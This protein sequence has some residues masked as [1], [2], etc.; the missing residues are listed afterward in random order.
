MRGEDIAGFDISGHTGAGVSGSDIFCAA[1]S[2]A[3][4]LTVNTITDVMGVEAKVSVSEGRLR[5]VLENGA[6]KQCKPLLIGFMLHMKQLK[7][8]RPKS[9]RI[10]KVTVGKEHYYA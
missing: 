6:E 9:I 7:E 8:Q 5:F 1:I 3:A 10:I 2:S 4:Y